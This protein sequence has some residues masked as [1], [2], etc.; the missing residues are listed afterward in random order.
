MILYLVSLGS[1][2]RSR[3]LNLLCTENKCSIHGKEPS[4][5]LFLSKVSLTIEGYR[6]SYLNTRRSR[7]QYQKGTT[8]SF[9]HSHLYKILNAEKGGEV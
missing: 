5:G 6:T 4:I 2:T 3:E 7:V 9:C 1:E 8:T